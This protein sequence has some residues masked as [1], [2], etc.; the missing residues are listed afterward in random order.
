MSGERN[1]W[2]PRIGLTYDIFGDGKT[3][4]KA[5]AAIYRWYTG[6]SAWNFYPSG[7]GSG[8][9]Q[10]ISDFEDS[11]AEFAMLR[12]LARRSGLPMSITILQ[13]DKNP[14]WWREIG[15]GPGAKMGRT[16][17]YYRL[18]DDGGAGYWVFREGLYQDSTSGSPCWYLHGVF[19]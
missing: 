8:W 10:V 6:F 3:I 15:A 18:E 14:E 16:R 13:R 12:R 19:G 7:V 4:F 5:N 11:D 2:S 9:M 17:D 1:L